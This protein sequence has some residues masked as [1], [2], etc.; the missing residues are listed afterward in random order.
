MAKQEAVFERTIAKASLRME[1]E[2][3]SNQEAAKRQADMDASV[4]RDLRGQLKD[5]D[6]ELETE[7]R[8]RV[9]LQDAVDALRTGKATEVS[10]NEQP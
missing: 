6:R 1:A 4:R 7:R 8:D 5:R 2:I 9:T 3:T 10:G